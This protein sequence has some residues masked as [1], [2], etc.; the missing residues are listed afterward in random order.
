MSC[1]P[2]STK[3]KQHLRSGY[4]RLLFKEVRWWVF[5]Y[6]IPTRVAG[7]QTNWNGS[8]TEVRNLVTEFI[9]LQSV[10]HKSIDMKCQP[11]WVERSKHDGTCWFSRTSTVAGCLST[12]PALS[13]ELLSLHSPNNNNEFVRMK[14]CLKKV[15][16]YWIWRSYSVDYISW[17]EANIFLDLRM[18]SLVES[19]DV[20]KESAAFIFRDEEWDI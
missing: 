9:I 10:K 17:F 8:I 4:T 6:F 11:S 14:W 12:P 18:Y 20:S 19:P 3:R 5:C 15:G 2:E 1:V 7:Q 16:T 13:F